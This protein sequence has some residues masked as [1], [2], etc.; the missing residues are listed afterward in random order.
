MSKWPQNILDVY[1]P[2]GATWLAELPALLDECAARWSLTLG[3][4]FG[5]L[6]YNYVA[7]AAGP[8]GAALVLK[9]GPPNPEL[10]SEIAA[11]RVFDGWGAA[12]LIAADAARGVLLVERVLPGDSLW[13]LD[14]DEQVIAVV[15]KVMRGLHRPLAAGHPFRTLT[16]LSTGLNRLRAEFDGGYGP[17][18]PARVDR[19]AGL[20][21]ELTGTAEPLLIHGDLNPGNVLRGGREPWLAIDP[22]GYAGDP[23]YDV[24]TFL[25]DAPRL[26]EAALRSLLDRRI[27]LLAEAL[28]VS[29]G[30]VLAWAEAHAV[31]SGWWN[32]EDHGAG[33]ERTFALAELYEALGR[34]K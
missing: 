12:R 25:N 32:Y 11:L 26:P 18:P 30:A 29:R 10:K 28:S 34:K 21:R 20:F 22:K 2:A 23:L 17:F 5:N 14:D 27:R 9:V 6:S 1:G 4:P 7:P 13:T 31:L 3:P 24:A 33:W 19:A 16:D 15:V 8:D